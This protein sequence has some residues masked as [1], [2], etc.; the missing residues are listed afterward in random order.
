MISPSISLVYSGLG[1]SLGLSIN[2]A[3]LSIIFVTSDH[4]PALLKLVPKVP[5][6]KTIVC[7]DTAPSNVSKILREWSQA[8]GLS[9]REFAERLFFLF[10]NPQSIYKLTFRTI[11]ESYGKANLIE[12]IPAYPDLVASICYTSVCLF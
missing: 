4:I 5:N 12:P 3:H 2:H 6:L 7:M 11:V 8:Q 10:F 1:S 9:F